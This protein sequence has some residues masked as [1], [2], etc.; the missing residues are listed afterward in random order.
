LDLSLVGTYSI[1]PGLT[2]A[3]LEVCFEESAAQLNIGVS[4]E[5]TDE[6]SP[7]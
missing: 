4:D 7:V 3:L 1:A 6:R 2:I 5:A